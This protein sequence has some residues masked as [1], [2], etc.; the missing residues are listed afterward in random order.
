[1]S[2]V[3]HGLIAAYR[4]FGP[5]DVKNIGREGLLVWLTSA[6][7]GIA[8][9]FR[10]GVPALTTVL[11]AQLGFD[12]APYYDLIMSGYV[13]TAAGI[14]GM[15]VGFLLLDERDE[16]TLTALLVTP[17]PMETYFAYRITL[18]LV[19]GFV[20][21]CVTYPLIGLAPISAVD[22]IV[23]AG[24]AAFGGP[25]V[26]LFLAVF[27][28]NKITGLA[29]TK[30]FNTINFIPVLAYFVSSDWQLLAGIVPGYW[31]MKVVWLAVAGE[32]YVWQAAV[33][34]AV[35]VAAVWLLLRRFTSIL[36]R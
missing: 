34:V 35:N 16:N 15:V 4:M 14:A 17:L 9:G 12:L 20:V 31:P 6:V 36:H 29:L 18:P 26:A 5:V 2:S 10:F 13:G 24:L 22:L 1:M 33:G 19:L 8:V 21:T 11:D 25:T 3:C 7:V 23:V 28:E 30:V 32:P 27:A